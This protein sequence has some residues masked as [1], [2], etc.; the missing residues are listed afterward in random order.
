MIEKKNALADLGLLLVAVIWGAGFSATQYAIDAGLTS[1]TILLLRFLVAALIL[2]AVCWKQVVTVTGRE[3]AYGALS[4][5]FL[6]V[7]FFLQTEAQSRTTPSN[8][9]FLT[10]T[11]VVM[12]PFLIWV[13]TRRR[14]E[15]KNLILPFLAVAGIFVLGYTPGQGISFAVGDLL[16]LACA[17]F[18][19]C[20]IASLEFTAKHVEARK[21]TFIQMATAAGLSLLYFLIVDR[22]P[23]DGGTLRAGILPVLYLGAFSTC[24]CFFLQTAAQKHASASKAAIFLSME[25]MFG[26]LFSVLLGLE[27]LRWTLVFGGSLLFAC[28]VLT[29]LRFPLRPA[30]RE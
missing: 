29:E 24:L 25:G 1:A 6:F 10:T 4:G 3:W 12:V 17:F 28:A 16:S 11:N 8:C 21:L 20:H 9:A 13:V 5:F 19:A 18:F 14:P 2:G 7:A 15:A 26:S 27:P 22:S 23:V 30:H